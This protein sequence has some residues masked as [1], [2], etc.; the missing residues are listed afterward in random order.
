M[1]FLVLMSLLFAS[2]F[3]SLFNRHENV[4]PNW[5]TLSVKYAFYRSLPI[6][7]NAAII[8]SWKLLANSCEVESQFIGKRYALNN[9]LATVLMFDLNGILAGIQMGISE[10]IKEAKWFGKIHIKDVDTNYVTAYFTEPS[11]ICNNIIIRNKDYVGDKLGILSGK[12]LQD[13]PLKEAELKGTKW[14]KGKCVFGRG[15]H[16]WYNVKSDMDC[17]DF[18]PIFLL[19]NNKLLTGF[20]FVVCGILNNTNVERHNPEKLKY[21]LEPITHPKCID[22]CA[23]ISTQYVYLNE[24]PGL[25]SFC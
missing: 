25:N 12:E 1:V 17:S 21:L 10:D 14:T 3:G 22:A 2:V 24:N 23:D 5:K 8:S 20:G 11:D 13:M 9:D 7:E 16:Y 18:F 4:F 6:S 19:Y 15:Q